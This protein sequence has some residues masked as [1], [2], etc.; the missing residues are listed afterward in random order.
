MLL[1]YYW[2]MKIVSRIVRLLN[3][4]QK[5]QGKWGI[6]RKIGLKHHIYGSTKASLNQLA[7]EVPK[8][9]KEKWHIDFCQSDE[10]YNHHVVHNVFMSLS[11]FH[12]IPMNK[13]SHPLHQSAP[14]V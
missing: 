11:S 9:L 3:F 13:W 4:K 1:D 10:E 7:H 14:C 8:S 6:I 2:R 5:H 12:I